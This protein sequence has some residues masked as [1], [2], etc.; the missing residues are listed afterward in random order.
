MKKVLFPIIVLL[1]LGCTVGLYYL[2]FD[3]LNQ[4][5]DHL[6]Y[7]NVVSACLA[8]LLLLINI[9]IL[10]N[11]K[12]L[13][14]TNATVSICVNIYA[15][16]V[17]VWTLF[18]SLILHNTEP[19]NFKVYYVGILLLSL[20]FIAFCGV[21]AF[22]SHIAEKG[23]KEQETK[24]ECKSN[25]MHLIQ[26]T[27][28]EI[29]AS[30]EKEESEWKDDFVRLFNMTI[31]KLSSMPHEKLHNNPNIAN[32]VEDS[33]TEISTLC[34]SLAAA[35]NTEAVKADLTSKVNRLNKYLTTIKTL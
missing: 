5:I 29:L 18:F 15:V 14:V 17:F 34:D 28:L 4:P 31:D 32:K 30:L 6:F 13:N 35:E 2:I 22:S 1:T 3:L 19:E 33:L 8:E 25:V 11:E 10:S 26:A 20:A 24:M 21:S 16:A 9:P 23:V 27:N 7:I 12:I